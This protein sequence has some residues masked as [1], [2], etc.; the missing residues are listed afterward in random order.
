MPLA[1]GS[2]LGP[3]EVTAFI[4]EGG[5]GKVWRAHHTA[6]K[7]DD[8][9]KV[10][11][12]AF[13]SDPDRLARFRREAQ[14][15]ASLNHPNIAHVYGLEQ[16]DGVQALVMEL[17][18]GTTL[19]DR[20]SQGPIPVDQAL[21]IAKQ[22][23]EALEAA[24]EQGIIHRD[25]KPAN[26][27][28]RSDGTVKVLDFGLAK[29]LDQVSTADDATHSPTIIS[30]A[31]TGV[32]VL[33]GTAAYMSPEQAKGR[34]ADKRSDVWA[35][36]AVLFEML[37][38]RRAFAGGEVS[39]VLASVL[40]REP[41]WTRLPPDLSPSLTTYIKRCLQK[42]PKQRIGDV[43]S[44]RLALEG[45]FEA[46][47]APTVTTSP[48]ARAA[49]GWRRAMPW[50]LAGLLAVGVVLLAVMRP[51]PAPSPPVARFS[52]PLAANESFTATNRHALA[53]SPNGT[54]VAYAANQ[55]L[56][57]RSLDQLQATP[58]PGTDGAA[59]PFF[60][61][62]GQSIG[63]WA[64]GQLKRVSVTGGAPVTLGAVGI[65]FGASWEADGTILIGQ[66][67]KGIL[68]MPAAGGTPEVLIPVDAGQI[69]HGPRMLPGGEWVLF[70]LLRPGA[71]ISW[72]GAQIV[73]QSLAT[74][75]RIV[76]IEGGRDAN[77]L[78]TG[79]LVYAREATLLAVPFDLGARRVTGGPVPLVENVGNTG[80]SAG[81]FSVAARNGSL[82]YVAA[83]SIS[84]LSAPRTLVW[85]D[86]KGQ[87][88]PL[89]V[90]PRGYIYPRVSPDGTRVALDVRDG[91]PDI[92]IWDIGRETLTRLT[93]DP[94]ADRSPAWSPDGRRV[95][96]SSQRDASPGNLFWQAADGTGDADRLAE[97]ERDMFPTSF[98]P[99]ASQILINVAT[100]GATGGQGENDDIATVS[101]KAKGRAM[102]LLATM[103]GE[104]NGEVSPDGR[105]LAYESDESGREE[106]YVRP[107]PDVQSGRWQ[108]ST[109][110][111]TRP[112]WAR[113]GRELF[114][115]VGQ[116]RV[117]SVPIQRGE[118]FSAGNP[119]VVFEG[120]YLAPNS[121]RTYDV[122]PTGERFLML[123]EAGSAAKTSGS[124]P[125]IIVVQGWFEEL[126]RRVPTP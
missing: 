91:V 73:I 11:P 126:K 8:A 115:L 70:T 65:P 9:L 48:V 52:V 124:P 2:R 89:A 97:G 87:E 98:S 59:E 106:I 96:F 64:G 55:R 102:P 119:Q 6:L 26:V 53:L 122:S 50:A 68:R 104:R 78:P 14:V 39:E 31:M 44:L 62:D 20:I 23:A 125:S 38:G 3:Y 29:A 117:M 86:R 34:A 81:Q 74:G 90:P 28:V 13:A 41:D 71:A 18:E 16:S 100:G 93:F 113:N 56:S 40:A 79:H 109:G 123:K 22:I 99:D 33:L 76:L 92:W 24:H 94:R 69:V 107:F 108:V 51:D 5:M 19:A 10:L 1:P 27:K 42:D 47:A 82:V 85:V 112:L 21:F 15:L 57:L 111:G 116:G 66:G 120:P 63:F 110:G 80:G 101:L 60:S 72:D 103:F 67:P 4:G 54:H 49:I 7:R 58:I 35:F 17:V 25:L 105:W 88:T 32:G 30:P 12:D 114:Y 45:A 121:G 118:S 83:G 95:A 75:E 36:G 61:P 37:T 43:Q 84:L 77:Y 46:G